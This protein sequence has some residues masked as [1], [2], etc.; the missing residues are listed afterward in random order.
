MSV[1]QPQE[2]SQQR[3]VR[4][5]VPNRI[6]YVTYGIMVITIIMFLLQQGSQFLLGGDWPAAWMMKVNMLIISGQYWRL[7]TPVLLHAG[8]IHIAFNMYALYAF[9]RGL[10]NYYGHGRYLLLYL[11]AGLAGNVASFTFS[12]NNSLGASTAVF[13]LIAAEGVFVYQNREFF[14]SRARGIITNLL[15]VVGINLVLGMSPGI[16][17]WGHMGGLVGGFAFA[18]FAGPALGLV[19][20]SLEDQ[21]G[22]QRVLVVA[23]IEFAVLVALAAARIMR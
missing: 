7:I 12:P 15:V 10:E 9:G 11:L 23:M 13:G 6:P 21:V 8:I 19:G 17:N 3:T 16:D 22:R 20:M 18:W 1:E 4:V 5:R 2:V 14:G